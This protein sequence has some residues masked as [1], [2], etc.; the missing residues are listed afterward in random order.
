MQPAR[1]NPCW[2]PWEYVES[3]SCLAFTSPAV[4]RV[5]YGKRIG[6]PIPPWY[7]GC[8]EMATPLEG[9]ADR[10]RT[11]DEQRALVMSQ[12]QC[13][14]LVSSTLSVLSA[15]YLHGLI[16]GIGGPR[17]ERQHALLSYS[18]NFHKFRLVISGCF[19]SQRAFLE[20]E[21][22]IQACQALTVNKAAWVMYFISDIFLLIWRSR[23]HPH[24][25]WIPHSST[26]IWHCRVVCCVCMCVYVCVPCT[27]FDWI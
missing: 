21:L 24:H 20:E 15:I 22:H 5:W 16:W 8:R 11:S 13:F 9:L 12:C 2:T 10:Q 3:V 26:K 4:S 6:E 25:R 7:A 1:G 19:K 23:C 14:A 18:R 17:T 27:F